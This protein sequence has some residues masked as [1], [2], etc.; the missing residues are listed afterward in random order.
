LKADTSQEIKW[1]GHK[2]GGMLALTGFNSLRTLD[3]SRN[4]LTA[5]T[6]D[7]NTALTSAN[8]S[9]NK[10]TQLSITGCNGLTNLS[11]N[12]NRLS[13]INLT[14]IPAITN[15]NLSNNPFCGT[16]SEQ[17][18]HAKDVELSGQ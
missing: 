12:N 18:D 11:A 2:L 1:K 8:V 13:D 7:D 16:Q 5:V 10:L 9:R 4:A 17:F 14:D 6:L 3:V 15:L